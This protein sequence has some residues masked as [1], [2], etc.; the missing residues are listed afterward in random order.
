MVDAIWNE[1][2]HSATALA[3][4]PTG[5]GKTFTIA[6]LMDRA[7]RVKPDIRIA[8][9]MGR[10][11]L[12][13]QTER[14]LSSRIG[15]NQVGVFCGSLGRK[16]LSKRVTVASIQ[17][18]A[19][20]G[21]RGLNML[22]IDEAHN[23]D[24]NGGKYM[25]F[26]EKAELENPKLKVIGV[27]A[28]PFRS[29]GLIY[30][31]DKFFKRL[32]FQRTIQDMIGL[33]YLCE[34]KLKS[35]EHAFDTSKLGTRA[36]E[37]IQE[38]VDELVSNEDLVVMQV[39]DALSKMDTRQC[40]AWA[41]ANIDHC[42][43]VLD[44][45]WREGQHA[46]SV[47]SKQDK[48]I[49]SANL[50]AFIGGSCRHMVFVS[51]L[52]EGF[53]HPPIDCVVLMRPTRSPVLYVQT[54]G[55]GIRISP[56]TGKKN[57]LVLD[58]GE[59]VRTLGPLDAPKV[60]GTKTMEGEAPIKECP[61]CHSWVFAG[62]RECSE[63]QYSFPPPP[64]PE[65]KLT[66]M[67]DVTAQILSTKVAAPEP[68]TQSLGPAVLTM[69]EAKSGNLC[70][71]ITYQDKSFFTRWGI[72]GVSEF[73]VTSS[74]W[75]MDRLE[76]RLNQI[77]GQ[78]PKIPFEGEIK[79][80]GTFEVVT[81]QEGKYERVTR[82]KRISDENPQ[83]A[84]KKIE[85]SWMDDPDDDP[86]SFNFG[87]NV[88]RKEAIDD[89]SVQGSEAWLRWREKG[90]G[91]SDAA[92]LLGW[93]PWK[94]IQQ[95]YEEKLGLWKPTFG[96]FQVKAM[97]RGKE[98]EPKIRAWY[99]L[100]RGEKFPDHIME[101][102]ELRFMRAS[103]DGYNANYINTED[104][105]VGR[106]I[107]IKA[108]SMKDHELAKNGEVPQKYI[109]QINWLM[110]V[111]K[112][113]WCDYVSFG[114]DGTYAIVPMRA[115][116][117]IQKELIKR[118]KIFWDCVEQKIALPEVFSEKW[119]YPLKSQLDLALAES[120]MITEQEIEG[121]VSETLK[122]QAELDAADARFQALKEKLKSLLGDAEKRTC[123]EAVFGWQTRKGNV[124]Y[125]KIPELATVDLEKYRGNDI[126]SFY[127]KRSK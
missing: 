5:S 73:F 66:P 47:H 103:F 101:C 22:V 98:L 56:E 29:K 84:E 43:R 2:T 76:M 15:R 124:E 63:C 41:T 67:P 94:T 40:A 35:G 99:E 91:S 81:L 113:T 105:T 52:S 110:L 79:V 125:K 71:K 28:T 78:L 82:I 65:E 49:R 42:N 90:I 108:P 14:A 100:L 80:Q 121:L 104:T 60:K 102:E 25:R 26:I 95:L 3:Q 19:E 109:P 48:S 55:R 23:L 127:F 75:A 106:I 87:A 93:S 34:P 18:I 32:C 37:F 114:T 69:H 61:Q 20:I 16:E 59:V 44:I 33:G 119:N 13:D 1:I 9:V 21:I 88:E 68:V 77:G 46:T 12:V 72:G 54:V 107:E 97:D 92:V 4:L 11:Q 96:I 10:V 123:G 86:A 83:K 17:S 116:G 31:E 53:D 38:Q 57:C 30:G 120:P 122:A 62:V 64:A 7:I 112:I 58:Y 51:V 126:K 111:G 118:A 50:A 89:I 39:R 70:V 24:Q 8:M 27:T 115:D 117:V 74:P 6:E 85:T 36:G 45:L